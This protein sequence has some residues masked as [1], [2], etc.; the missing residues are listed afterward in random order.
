MAEEKPRRLPHLE[1]IR[2]QATSGQRNEPDVSGLIAP[3]Y[4]ST[5]ILVV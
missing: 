3:L 4:Y 5:G 2:G 1:R